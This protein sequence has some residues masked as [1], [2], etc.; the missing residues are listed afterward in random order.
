MIITISR[1]YGAG[2]SEIARRVAEALGWTLV[3]NEL[4]DEVAKR[5]GMTPEEVAQ[6]HERA[7]GF[8]ERLARTLASSAPDVITTQETPMPGR[9][10][11]KLV[12][13]TESVVAE[14]AEQDRVVLV[15]RAA[16]AVLGRRAGTLHVKV[17]A[18]RA[19]RISV[20]ARRLGVDLKAAEKICDD[21]DD[22]RRRYHRTYYS[23]DWDDPVNYDMV[24]NT[25]AL[26]FD[27]A[28]EI[29]VG[30]AKWRWPAEGKERR[31]G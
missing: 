2:G 31:G 21:T 17:V 30:R 3:D 24:L 20:A 29:I 27:E 12:R 6:Y 5:A 22:N 1:Q 28:V 18:P 13:L 10:E 8:I 14:L 7:P 15:G 16:P 26:G 23:R 4:V 9:T 11:E 25:E 19:W